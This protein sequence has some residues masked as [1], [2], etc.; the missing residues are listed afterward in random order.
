MNNVSVNQLIRDRLIDNSKT[1]DIDQLRKEAME[2]TKKV[3]SQI[4][5]YQDIIGK[6][7]HD[8]NLN[9]IKMKPVESFT[10]DIQHAIKTLVNKLDDSQVFGSF[11]Y[12]AQSF[13]GDLDI[14]EIVDICCSPEDATK[15]MASILKKVVKRV[16]KTR[17]YYFSEVKSGNDER[18]IVDP[19][20]PDYLQ[21]IKD[22]HHQGLLDDE[23]F[24]KLKYASITKDDDEKE[25][26]KED[27]RQLYVLRWTEKEILQGYKILRGGKKI[28][29]AQ[30]MNMKA[31]I[32]ID[33]LA[34]INGK[35]IEVTNF[36]ILGY[37][38]KNGDHAL[39][40]SDDFDYVKGLLDQIKKLSSKAFFNPF[41][42]AKRMWG[43]A[44]HLKNKKLLDILTPLM[45]SGIARMN[46]IKSEIEVIQ[47]ILEK[48]KSPPLATLKKQIDDFKSRLSYVYDI[49]LSDIP[50]YDMID[51]I[52]NGKMSKE[53]IIKSLEIIK[54]TLKKEVSENALNFL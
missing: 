43:L 37:Y 9:V 4:E 42:L 40:N 3:D 29:L 10:N 49:V 12:R 20:E 8:D 23:E 6:A 45:Q 24:N 52:V 15:R 17:G 33:I 13:P 34:P 18:F 51:K 47:L 31:H 48:V 26:I 19:D 54:E 44:R 38:D 46:Q 28:T 22:L 27:I 39:I 53:K 35:Y 5:H 14:H 1:T 2:A 32:K 11:M 7:L 16:K 41:K 30:S 50:I 25:L 21:K 36:F